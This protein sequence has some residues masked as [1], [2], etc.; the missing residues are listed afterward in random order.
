[1]NFNRENIRGARITNQCGLHAAAPVLFRHGIMRRQ[2]SA[3]K[4]WTRGRARMGTTTHTALLATVP[5]DTVQIEHEWF[6]KGIGGLYFQVRHT[7]R[8][9]NR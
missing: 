9:H 6:V 4:G 1:M 8:I 5:L 3:T 7:K 2:H